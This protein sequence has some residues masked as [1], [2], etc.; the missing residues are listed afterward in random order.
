M[1]D[2]VGGEVIVARR[3][4]PPEQISI[5]GPFAEYVARKLMALKASRRGLVEYDIVL[6][7][8]LASRDSNEQAELLK[9]LDRLQAEQDA[10]EKISAFA[11]KDQ[12]DQDKLFRVAQ[13]SDEWITLSPG[14]SFR[15]WY[16][17]MWDKSDQG[18]CGTLMASKAWARKNKQV[19]MKGEKWYCVCCGVKYAIKFGMAVE[20]RDEDVSTFLRAEVTDTIIEDVRAMSLEETLKPSDHIDLWNQLEK[21]MPL[22]RASLFRDC[23]V[24]EL[25]EGA[26]TPETEAACREGLVMKVL[27]PETWHSL[28]MIKWAS[29]FVAFGKNDHKIQRELKAA[30]A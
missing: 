24:T 18:P 8:F 25:T 30:L 26:R 11:L 2:E 4:I 10:L 17:C 28:P 22:D 27:D 23:N 15:S 21:V 3:D 7:K 1:A 9:E 12:V 6:H 19:G 20:V 13:Y 29:I 14:R 5:L 16:T